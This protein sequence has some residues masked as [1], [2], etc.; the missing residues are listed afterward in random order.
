MLA[1]APIRLSSVGWRLADLV[2]RFEPTGAGNPNPVFV[3]RNVTVRAVDQ[4][5]THLR[6]MLGQGAAVRR[7]VAFR[8]EF[9]PPEPDTEIDALYE[10]E[11]S[12]WGDG[13]RI[14]LV[15]RDVR[16]AQR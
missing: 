7:A 11:R 5:D 10:V 9:E 14:D 16:P 15:L 3:S 12:F 13:A 4:A 1:D 6:L 8:A 2:A